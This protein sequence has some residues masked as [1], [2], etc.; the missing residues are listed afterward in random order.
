MLDQIDD[1][2]RQPEPIEV[3][4]QN[5]MRLFQLAQ[6]E[7]AAE[8]FDEDELSAI[9]Q[10]VCREFKLDEASRED[11]EQSARRAMDIAK[12]VKQTK[13]TPW[14]GASNVKY[15]MLTVAALQF[16]ARS[17]PAILD[18]PRIVKCK[19]NGYDPDGLK[20]QQADRVSI[21]MSWQLMEALPSW[22]DDMD[23]LLHQIPIV[24]CAFKKVYPDPGSEAN[25]NS[26]LA[27]AFDVV[28]NNK[29]RSLQTVPRITHVIE[30]YPHEIQE[31]MRSG[32]F[33]DIDLGDEDQGEDTEEPKRFLEQHRWYDTDGDGMKE[34]W[35]VTVHETSQKVVRI[36]AGYDIDSI[37]FDAERARITKMEKRKDIRF[38][39]I[40]FMPD[41]DGGFYGIGFGK[42][43]E[44]ISDVTDTCINQ[45]MD[46]GTLQNAGGGFIG[47]GLKLGKSKIRMAP[48]LW[49]NVSASGQ[50]VRAAIVPMN[51]PGPAPVLFQLLGMMIDAGKDVAAVKDILT[52]ES[53][54]NMTATT[55]M[56][57]IEQGLKVFSSIFKRVLRALANEF[58]VIY[59]INRRNM[60]ESV[61]VNLLDAPA[62][63]FRSD[64][65]DD[66]NVST[67]ADP[68]NVTDMQRAAKAEFLLLQVEKGNP[69]INPFAATKR[70]LESMRIEA[71]EEVLQPP[72]EGPNPMEEAELG[73]ATAEAEEA[74][75]KAGETHADAM[76]K[77]AEAARL[78]AENEM[79]GIPP[80]SPMPMQPQEAPPPQMDPMEQAYAD[81]LGA[82]PGLAD[83][84]MP[85]EMQGPEMP[86]DYPVDP[87]VGGP[88]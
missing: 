35:I 75:A 16:A 42:L 83:G 61:M 3:L 1:E 57:L 55:T 32:K 63:V 79:L 80:V 38:V 10:V 45:M 27:S 36:V 2:Q 77:S 82:M 40:P 49:Q 48:G 21:H 8:E 59:E 29:A 26:E 62:E 47:S 5:V 81:E 23:T 13:S 41:P 58:D 43:L 71:V 88:I 30:L 73:K 14:E 31:R 78:M 51:H 85:D 52:G 25:C 46:A 4:Q 50:D 74:A 37:E 9:G 12:Q 54:Q 65:S 68:N 19:I 56:A 28:V 39:M 44:S 18:G 6:L 76:K 69:H 15:P 64:Y 72:P 87:A 66:L 22:E 20:A 24:G 33:L 34:P 67:V 11:W 60:P 70:A 53:Q 17:Y 86:A 84:M 7:N